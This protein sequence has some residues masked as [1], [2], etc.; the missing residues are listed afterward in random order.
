LRITGTRR[1]SR[2]HR[3][4]SRSTSAGSIPT[5]GRWVWNW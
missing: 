3:P 2:W 5:P 4:K 1:R